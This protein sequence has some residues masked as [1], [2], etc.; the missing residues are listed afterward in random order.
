ML[1]NY[2]KLSFR[3]MARNP[4]F[5]F[6]NVMGLSLGFAAFFVLW[7][8]SQNE[9]RSD[10]F[11]KDYEQIYRL[12]ALGEWNDDKDTW[13]G[14]VVGVTG[15]SMMDILKKST[16]VL[17]HTA[18]YPPMSY[19]VHGSDHAAEI[20]LSYQRPS[21]DRIS[22]EETAV[23]YAEQNF[24]DFFAFP[25][26]EGNGTTCLTEPQSVV[27]SQKTA[28]KYFGTD[29]P[30]GKT[31]ELNRQIGL[32][33]TGVFKDLPHNTHFIF[34]VVISANRIRSYINSKPD[35]FATSYCKF[36]SG[37]NVKA[38]EEKVNSTYP[39]EVNRAIWGGWSGGR[40]QL[41]LQPLTAIA[42]EALRFDLHHSKS[43]YLLQ[44]FSIAAIAGSVSRTT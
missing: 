12:G 18:I 35:Y 22:H 41:R 14:S 27:I 30:V 19:A 4:F 36:P 28:A 44:L 40:A 15:T 43:R 24:F 9:L 13:Q 26:E 11:H 37:T 38:V 10:R 2:I 42:F 34:D 33:V 25:L 6:I 7:Q 31:I 21:G 1:L 23:V 5:S 8:H 16:P 20:S 32:T 29:N 3:L 39:A 17:D